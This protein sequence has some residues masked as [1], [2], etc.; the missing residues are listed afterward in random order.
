VF[1]AGFGH[2]PNVDAALWFVR[3]VWPSVLSAQ[4]AARHRPL[5][6]DAPRMSTTA[7]GAGRTAEQLHTV[8][9]IA[10]T[11]LH[12]NHGSL[13]AIIANRVGAQDVAADVAAL[14]SD[15]VPAYAIPEE[16]LLSAPSVKAMMQVVDCFIFADELDM[17]ECRLTEL[18]EV[19]DWFVLVEAESTF[20]GD[21]KPLAYAE[22][23]DRFARW[24]D[25]IVHVVAELPD[26]SAWIREAAQREAIIDGLRALPLAPDD[27]IVL[28][29][30]DEIWRPS[31]VVTVTRPIHWRG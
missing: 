28:S 1:V 3:E 29:D 15:D 22:H 12:A 2:P 19:V 11:E 20:Q 23:R 8:T 17:L 24:S 27:T 18:E 25:R 6:P 9:D 21:P 30:V 4:P 7:N 31:V 13:F 26:A 16:P 14:G 5:D 10:V